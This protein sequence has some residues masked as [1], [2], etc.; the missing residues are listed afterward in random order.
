MTVLSALN[1]ITSLLSSD[2]AFLE[3]TGERHVR[4][5]NTRDHPQ[6]D[7]AEQRDFR[8]NIESDQNL[9][10]IINNHLAV[11]NDTIWFFGETPAD[12]KTELT[13]HYV[14]SKLYNYMKISEMSK[15][16]ISVFEVTFAS[17]LSYLTEYDIIKLATSYWCNGQHFNC[18]ISHRGDAIRSNSILEDAHHTPAILQLEITSELLDASIDSGASADKIGAMLLQKRID[19]G[20]KIRKSKCG[21]TL[22]CSMKYERD[23][24]LNNLK[25]KFWNHEVLLHVFIKNGWLT[26]DVATPALSAFVKSVYTRVLHSKLG[27]VKKHVARSKKESIELSEQFLHALFVSHFEL[28]GIPNAYKQQLYQYQPENDG[29]HE[30]FE[31]YQIREAI[32]TR[33]CDLVELL[34]SR[35]ANVNAFVFQKII[36]LQYALQLGKNTFK[37]IS[38]SHD[39]KNREYVPHSWHAQ[40]IVIPNDVWDVTVSY[41]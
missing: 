9:Q 28:K 33:W 36:P 24:Y 4:A 34:A 5:I 31:V 14:L 30:A 6:T 32:L 22:F 29:Y 7:R 19:D 2:E 16:G 26:P 17:Y 18:I 12:S 40:D 11:D 41:L 25:H 35:G 13:S 39:M 21:N 20:V 27:M 8:F 15:Y 23:F 37:I 3:V 1:R 38:S 10:T